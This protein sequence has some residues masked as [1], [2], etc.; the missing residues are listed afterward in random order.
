MHKVILKSLIF[1]AGLFSALVLQLYSQA[2]I[3]LNG[4]EETTTGFNW[5]AGRTFVDSD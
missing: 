3:I 5:R 1:L 2:I 4:M